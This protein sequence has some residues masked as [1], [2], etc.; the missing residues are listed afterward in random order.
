MISKGEE[1]SQ[2]KCLTL[3]QNEGKQK[4]SWKSEIKKAENLPLAWS[5]C[6]QFNQTK[7]TFTWSLWVP[8]RAQFC[9]CKYHNHHF[10]KGLGSSCLLRQL[11]FAATEHRAIPPCWRWCHGREAWLS[12]PD[13]TPPSFRAFPTSSLATLF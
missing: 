10:H 11:H 8:I 9:K 1:D 7:P 3:L 5:A 12:L 4:R 13:S 2:E 6:L